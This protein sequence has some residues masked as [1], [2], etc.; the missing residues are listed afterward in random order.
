MACGCAQAKHGM[1]ASHLAQLIRKAKAQA[2][3]DA[4]L[5]MPHAH[6]A[7]PEDDEPSENKARLSRESPECLEVNFLEF[8]LLMRLVRQEDREAQQ[9]HLWEVFNR[10]D[11]DGSGA[12]AVKEISRL[13][14]DLGIQP[15]TRKEQ[16]EIRMI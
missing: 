6:F 15:R 12:I 7:I 3:R 13:F 10:Y 16:L 14:G 5:R 1:P 9:E 11:S 2:Q 4:R 8:L